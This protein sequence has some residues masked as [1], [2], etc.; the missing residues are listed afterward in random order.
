M[1]LRNKLG[2]VAATGL[3][4]TIS[5]VGFA[6]IA[7]ADTGSNA[8]TVPII[9]PS[10][11][12]NTTDLQ[13]DEPVQFVV[14]SGDFTPS[15]NVNV[16]ECSDP[17]GSIT[18]AYL[19]TLSV[20]VCDAL[21]NVPYQATPAGGLTTPDPTVPADAPG[22]G[23]PATNDAYVVFSLPNKPVLGEKA[24]NAKCDLTDECI[25][26]LGPSLSNPADGT[27][28][29]YSNP[30]FVDQNYDFLGGKAAPGTPVP[31]VPYDVL[32][33]IA[34]AGLLGGA[35]LIGRRRNKAVISA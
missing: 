33:P 7:S 24:S 14:P 16:Y 27:G 28:V 8:T 13:N 4:V 17:S 18:A 29:V 2:G 12:A 1:R 5:V 34:A 23:A 10:N 22:T 6:G 25:I 9:L 20:N 19:D 31:E 26:Y 15:E 11:A 32:L 3:I 21:T 35:Y 30:F